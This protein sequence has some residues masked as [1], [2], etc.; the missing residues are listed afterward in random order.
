MSIVPTRPRGEPLQRCLMKLPSRRSESAWRS[1]AWVFITIGPYQ[2]TGSSSG[3]PEI[4]RK[5]M[6]SL[7]GLHRHLVA[8]CRTAPASGCRS[9]RAPGSRRLALLGQDAERLRGVAERSRALEDIGERVPVRLD[10]QGL[11][12]AR[13]D[14][15]VEVARIGGDAVDRAALAPELAAHHAHAG[16]VVVDD[17]G[18]L[19]RPARPGSGVRSS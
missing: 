9:A 1:S 6:P 16:A 17:L 5:R 11:A 2:A 19:A 10:R 7:A 4:S 14:E 13:R 18:N 8:A 15:D 12:P 3:L